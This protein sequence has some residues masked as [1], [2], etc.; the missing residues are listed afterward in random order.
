MTRRNVLY[1]IIIGFIM[2]TILLYFIFF[3]PNEHVYNGTLASS[4]M[5]PYVFKVVQILCLR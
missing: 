1:A 2:V 4:Q 5:S 3:M